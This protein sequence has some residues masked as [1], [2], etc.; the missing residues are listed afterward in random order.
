MNVLRDVQDASAA[1]LDSSTC[2]TASVASGDDING[3]VSNS[4]LD[5]NVDDRRDDSASSDIEEDAEEEQKEGQD[6]LSFFC[7][8]VYFNLRSICVLLPFYIYF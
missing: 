4:F 2:D 8:K 5:H 3:S 7:Y 1:D 6:N